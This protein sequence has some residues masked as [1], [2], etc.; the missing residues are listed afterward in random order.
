M[1]G[2]SDAM[3]ESL[4]ALSHYLVDEVTLGDTL[5]RV[6]QLACKATPADMA[7]LTMLVD[8]TPGTAV[9]TDP[10]APEIDRTQYATGQG[11]CLDA[12]RDLVVYRIDDTADDGRW[13]EFAATARSHGIGSTLSVPVSAQGRSLGALNL[14]ALQPNGF[15]DGSVERVE[16]FAGHAAMVLANASSYWDARALNENL[17]QALR[18]RAVIDQAIGVLMAG[19]AGDPERAF[20]T[21]VRASQ[22]ENRKVRD[23]AVEIVQRV[24]EVGAQGAPG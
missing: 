18:S 24:V 23:L 17:Q 12:L 9:F 2:P 10:D 15:D 14:Y 13:P 19:G 5:L 7:G 3:H 16:V 21:L 11:P 4:L 1:A 22:R 20:Q 6:S 8:G